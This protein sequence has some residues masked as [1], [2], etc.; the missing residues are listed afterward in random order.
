AVGQGNTA[1]TAGVTWNTTG[2]ASVGN[3]YSPYRLGVGPDDS[4]YVSEA[5]SN[6]CTIYLIDPDLNTSTMLLSPA[7]LVTPGAN[8]G[9]P[10]VAQTSHGRPLSRPIAFG[11]LAAGTLVL[12]DI[13]CELNSVANQ[14]QKYVINGGPPPWTTAPS[15]SLGSAGNPTFFVDEDLAIAPDGK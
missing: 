8:I 2:G 1:K 10:G 13:D 15:A 11:S 3:T 14:I 7:G 4:V 5:M 6:T 9:S 12:Y